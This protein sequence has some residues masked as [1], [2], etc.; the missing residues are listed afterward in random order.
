MK[1]VKLTAALLISGIL[2]GCGGGGSSSAD[3]SVNVTPAAQPVNCTIELNADSLLAGIVID[4][5]AISI[6]KKRKDFIVTDKAV[7]GLSL[8][9]LANG[10]VAAYP[11]ALTPVF[12]A[13][14]P[15][16]R[17][18]RNSHVVVI[19]LG[20][21]DAYGNYP[22][23]EYYQQIESM[24]KVLKSEG[25]V[26]VLTGIVPFS[27]GGAYDQATIDRSIILNGMAQTLA[28]KYNVLNANLSTVPYKGITDTVDGLH[29][30]Q[31]AADLLVDRLIETLD[32]ACKR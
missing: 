2:V 18:A 8:R 1:L 22:A 10:Y 28:V 14:M 3:V 25:R 13:Q 30:K 4:P 17:V 31:P 6:M 15:F 26:P 32:V 23:E 20:A 7:I 16:D 9:S 12:G 19:E 29:R 27:L 24:I 5:F 11:G 21:N